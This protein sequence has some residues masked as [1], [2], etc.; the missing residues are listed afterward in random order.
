MSRKWPKMAEKWLRGLAAGII[1]SGDMYEGWGCS[2]ISDTV[3][4][5]GLD[6]LNFGS[7]NFGYG[8]WKATQ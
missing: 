2:S 8:R 7:M 1:L 3:I 5:T 4:V 6:S